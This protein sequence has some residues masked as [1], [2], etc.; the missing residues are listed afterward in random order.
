MINATL[1]LMGFLAFGQSKVLFEGHS[2]V[3]YGKQHGGFVIQRFVF[4]PEKKE[5]SCLRYTQAK[6][7]NQDEFI[8][9]LKGKADQSLRPLG[10]RYEKSTAKSTSILDASFKDSKGV[11]KKTVDGKTKEETIELPSGVFLFCF[12]NYAILKGPKG[13]KP[14]LRYNYRA[15][16]EEDG[17]V[18]EG[19]ALIRETEEK[20]GMPAFRI[21]N[22]FKSEKKP[23]NFVSYLSTDGETLISEDPVRQISTELV[24]TV[25]EAKRGMVPN[26]DKIRVTFGGIPKGQHNALSKKRSPEN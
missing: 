14:R 18:H 20:L 23:E 10:Y 22:T 25:E 5:Y 24:T 26:L 12:L 19:I 4:D 2:K 16:S 8:E 9:I 21:D 15:I 3:Q 7:P 13:A 17:E 1:L 11:I 6:P